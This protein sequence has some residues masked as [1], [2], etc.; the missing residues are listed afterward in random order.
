VDFDSIDGGVSRSGFI[1]TEQESTIDTG[2]HVDSLDLVERQLS[3]NVLDE[4]VLNPERSI[5]TGFR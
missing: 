4:S 3:E 2:A 5:P 1:G